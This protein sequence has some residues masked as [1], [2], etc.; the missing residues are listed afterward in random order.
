M[1]KLKLYIVDDSPYV[2]KSLVRVFSE[3]ENVEVIE[4]GANVKSA[5]KFLSENDPDVCLF[6]YNLPDGTAVDLIKY[7]GHKSKDVINIV[8]SNFADEQMKKMILRAGANYFFDKAN[9]IDEI[10]DL[11]IKLASEKK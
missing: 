9:E 3:I 1:E 8:I 2:R 6:D 10:T 7:L 4:E 5:L 11:I